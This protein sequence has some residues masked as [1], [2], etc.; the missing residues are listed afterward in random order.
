MSRQAST[1][2]ITFTLDEQVYGIPVA[3]VVRIIEMVTI[4][5]LPGV[6]GAIQGII[7][8]SG[9]AVPVLDLR[10]Q[11]GLSPRPYGL[12]TPI[13]LINRVSG[14]MMGLIVDY[15]EQVVDVAADALEMMDMFMPPEIMEQ[16]AIHAGYLVGIANIDDCIVS[17]LNVNSLLTT[18][19]QLNL[20]KAVDD[21]NL[22][23]DTQHLE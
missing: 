11:F 12:H 14:G 9:N 18:A 23:K 8:V 17:V 2:L 7:N 22:K 6:S 13:I 10:V 19:E 21:V 5:R 4:I 1:T 20:S 16:L 3:Y 15:V